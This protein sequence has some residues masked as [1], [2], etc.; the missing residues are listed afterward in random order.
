MGGRKA[1]AGLQVVHRALAKS[2]KDRAPRADKSNTT[3]LAFG[4]SGRTA[5]GEAYE[6][7]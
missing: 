6:D 1:P 3:K 2:P 7:G 5:L 4:C